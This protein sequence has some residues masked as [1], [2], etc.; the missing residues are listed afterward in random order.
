MMRRD[1]FALGALLGLGC[2]AAAGGDL[3]VWRSHPLPAPDQAGRDWA[4]VG[5]FKGDS[6][7]LDSGL[8][9]D[10][11]DDSKPSN[12]PRYA[13]AFSCELETPE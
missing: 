7:V 5:T 10:D 12:Q 9:H 3:S 2:L 6:F 11:C 1:A 8:T 4:I 13:L